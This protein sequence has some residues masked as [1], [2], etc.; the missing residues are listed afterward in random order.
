MWQW[1]CRG[2]VNKK[3]VLQQH[4]RTRER[5][6]GVIQLQETLN[7][8]GIIS[9]YQEFLTVTRLGMITLVQKR[10]TAITHEIKRFKIEHVLVVL[11]QER[12]RKGNVRSR[13]VYGLPYVYFIV[14]RA[15]TQSLHALA[16]YFLLPR[17]LAR[18]R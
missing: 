3:A 7:T 10:C 15:L 18:A 14:I 6:P 2:S 8:T 12:C 9:G 17:A 16:R 4:I 1:N 13:L 5:K 11:L